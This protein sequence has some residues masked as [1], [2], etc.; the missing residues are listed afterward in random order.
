MMEDF[1][2]QINMPTNMKELG[3]EPTEEQILEMTRSCAQAA[4]GKKGS[5]KVLYP[6]DM[7]AIYRMA[8]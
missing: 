4:G 7:A 1:Y 6:E 3:I 2:R 8:L 5:A